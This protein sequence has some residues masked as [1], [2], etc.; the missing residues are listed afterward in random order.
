[1]KIG[2]MFRSPLIIIGLIL[3]GTPPAYGNLYE[4]LVE[5]AKTEMAMKGGKLE[6]ALD[7]PEKDAREV[8]SAFQ[9][10]YPFIKE[11][12][13]TRETGIG[14][15]GRYLIQ[16]KQGDLP[17]YD[18]L[19]VASEFEAQ[20]WQAGAFRKPLLSYRE[21]NQHL[22]ADWPKL[23]DRAMDPAGSFLSTTG[24]T[25][26]IIYNATLVPE[27]KIPTTWDDCLDPMWRRQVMMDAR[28]KLQSLQH[29][30]KTREAHLKWLR[31]MVQNQ[32][33]L[34]RGQGS[35]VRKVASGEF[36][37]ACGMNYH[38][39][40]RIIDRG[41]RTLRY[42]Q[43]DS[44]YP[45]ELAS[46][47]FVAQW[48]Q[49]PATTQLWA[50]WISTAGQQALEKHAYRGFPWDPESKKYPMAM[51]KY[52]AVC[53]AECASK[54]DDYNREYQEILGLPAR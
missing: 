29:D 49:A 12:S 28:N 53:G 41:V 44:P 14:A 2:T 24:S 46:R 11:I 33:V 31:G 16:F 1:M 25:R 9:A 51:G 47:I 38:T 32:V 5:M 27:N 22:P 18:I 8:L 21:L 17:P 13:Y 45:L 40:F 43:P 50:V 19:H 20:Y 23:D 10:Q 26:G 7:W 39:A 35:I 52:I 6:M 37:L 54:W 15:F 36:P 34:T 4:R 30:P 42:V 3:L 48:S